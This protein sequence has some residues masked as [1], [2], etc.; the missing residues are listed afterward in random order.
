MAS[1]SGLGKKLTDPDSYD[2]PLVFLF[3]CTVALVGFI[4]ITTWGLH[5]AGLPGFLDILQGIH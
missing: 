4:G 1:L 2:H 5:K 3:F